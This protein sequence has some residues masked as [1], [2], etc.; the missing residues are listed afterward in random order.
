MQSVRLTSVCVSL[1]V[2]RSKSKCATQKLSLTIGLKRNK[3]GKSS[4]RRPLLNPWSSRSQLRCVVLLS[5]IRVYRIVG[6]LWQIYRDKRGHS[7]NRR[8]VYRIDSCPSSMIAAHPDDA[9]NYPVD[10]CWSRNGIKVA[11][12][13]VH[14]KT[15]KAPCIITVP[16]IAASFDRDSRRRK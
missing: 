16:S 7:V 3:V 11:S 15:P 1:L 8:V 13:L 12:Y 9:R 10:M 14:A 5:F 4:N 6:I 2:K